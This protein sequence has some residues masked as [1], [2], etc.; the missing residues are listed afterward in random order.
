MKHY[1]LALLS[2]ALLVG[3]PACH[4]DKKSSKAQPSHKMHEKKDKKAKKTKKA[5]KDKKD[6][7]AKKDKKH[8][9]PK[10][11]SRAAEMKSEMKK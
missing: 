10:E 5:K 2:L 11:S 4:R 6:K 7:K 8:A 1:T 3:T 9:A